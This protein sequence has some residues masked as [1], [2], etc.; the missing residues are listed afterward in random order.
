MTLRDIIMC[1]NVL[2]YVDSYRYLGFEICYVP[3]KS[4]DLKIHH[5]FKEDDTSSVLSS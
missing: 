3:T 4:D 2:A 5:Q 1:D